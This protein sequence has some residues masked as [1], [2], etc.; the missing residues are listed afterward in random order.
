MIC[1]ARF[2]YCVYDAGATL[3]SLV[4]MAR[5]GGEMKNLASDPEHKEAL[6]RHRRYLKDWV[7]QSG[8]KEGRAFVVQ[9]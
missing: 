4:D 1:S 9:G 2:K 6:A 7:K 5:D 8:D 3:E